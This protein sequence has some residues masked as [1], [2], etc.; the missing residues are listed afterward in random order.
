MH[1]FRVVTSCMH[2]TI[3]KLMDK[4]AEHCTLKVNYIIKVNPGRNMFRRTL[5]F[6]VKYTEFSIDISTVFQSHLQN[7]VLQD[8]SR[9][10]GRQL[11]HIF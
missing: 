4:F 6:R 7:L 11:L 5:L 9:D 2:S 8:V 10:S 3:Q 1:D